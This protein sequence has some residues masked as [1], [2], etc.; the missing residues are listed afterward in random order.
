MP[1]TSISIEIWK[2]T[3]SGINTYIVQELYILWSEYQDFKKK[4]YQRNT[5][6]EYEYID[7][8]CDVTKQMQLFAQVE[9]IYIYILMSY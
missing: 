1:S 6:Y 4:W 5:K 7:L 3:P 2:C 9:N 8:L